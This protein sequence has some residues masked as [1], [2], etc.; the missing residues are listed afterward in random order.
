MASNPLE[1]VPVKYPQDVFDS[2]KEVYEKVGYGQQYGLDIWIT[3]VLVVGFF[4]ATA[5]FY[6]LGH[7]QPIKADWPVNRCNPA[8]IPFAGIINPPENG[9]AM[10]YTGENFE[11]CTQNV[12]KEI[13][14]YFL[15]PFYYLMTVIRETI[16]EMRKAADAIR[17]E[18]DKVR[19]ALSNITAQIMARVE[20]AIVPLTKMVITARDLFGKTAGVIMTGL[21]TFMTA[22]MGLNSIFAIIIDGILAGLILL[23]LLIIPLWAIA[24]VFPPAAAL[25]IADTAVFVAILALFIIFKVFLSE[26]MGIASGDAPPVP[27]CF[28]KG[29]PLLMKEGKTR[30]IEEVKI[31]DVLVDDGVV[32]GVMKMSSRGQDVYD[33]D[34]I[35]VTGR[36]RVFHPEAGLIQ[37]AAHPAATRIHDFREE[38]V[39]CVNTSTKR[40]VIN[41]EVYVD[42]DDLDP[43]DM[44]ELDVNCARTGIVP[45]ELSG[46]DIH[47]HLECGLAAGSM[48]ELDDGR[49]LS[50]QELDVN[51]VLRFG[52]TV[53]GTVKLDAK[54]VICTKE[55]SLDA[56]RSLR[57]SG[58][59][60]ILDG[61]LGTIST[62]SIDGT[63][64]QGERYLYHLVTDVGSFVTDGVRVGDYNTGLEQHLKPALFLSR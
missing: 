3:V 49:S 19:D 18:F 46:E 45:H 56:T 1:S 30:A 20:N 55:Y 14:G 29:T 22:Y 58:N 54:D 48:V 41:S 4:C 33:I 21:Y 59:V 24:W 42:W 25:A 47:H 50:I 39:Y 53:L 28:A 16:D 9:S 10:D 34:G 43:M 32:T 12:L 5:Y 64:M 63:E 8:Y 60:L 51:D 52:E 61:D 7:L 13:T 23:A 15:A 26:V 17:Q 36:H 35:Y 62:H 40:L 44:Y 31:G 6:I 11:Y 27:A 37:A 57:G 38:Y 2:V